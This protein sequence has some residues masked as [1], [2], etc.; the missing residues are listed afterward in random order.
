MLKD[1]Q[2]NKLLLQIIDDNKDTEYG[3]KYH[4]EYL[5]TVD[6]YKYVLPLSEV[7]DVNP[8][9]ELTTRIGENNIFVADKIIAYALTS[10]TTSI[11]HYVPVTKKHIDD[12]K[13]EFVRMLSKLGNNIVLFESI[14]NQI[15]YANM[16]KLDT[17]SGSILQEIKNNLRRYHFTS[18]ECLLFKQ[19]NID[20][21]YYRALFALN[22]A[23]VEKIIAPFSW[24][25]LE[26]IKCII[27]N[28]DKLLN[29][30]QSATITFENDTP[31]D[32]KQALTNSYKPNP[33]RCKYLSNVLTKDTFTLTDLWPQLRKVYAP[34]T[35]RF[36]IYRDNLSQYLGKAKLCNGFFVSSEAILGTCFDETDVYKLY[37]KNAYI[38]F[39]DVD[40]KDDAT[41][42]YDEVT[43]KH[44]YILY[45]TN[46]AGLYRYRVGDI[47]EVVDVKEGI[48]YF[49][50]VGRTNEKV[51]E[52]LVY[53]GIKKIM[54]A[55]NSLIQDYCFINSNKGLTILLETKDSQLLQSKQKALIKCFDKSLKV[56]D[57]KYL[58]ENSQL[59]YKALRGKLGN[60]AIDQL[61]P[62]R[63]INDQEKKKFFTSH[64]IK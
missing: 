15:V 20:T 6:G 4:F 12:Y 8:T 27:D 9:I 22:A 26:F 34:S 37:T 59:E 44:K 64:I 47:V 25:V 52:Q 3:K 55:T 31:E 11:N 30:L 49:K 57:I 51:D 2:F 40:A 53:A 24:N 5:R 61:K 43:P 42:L 23:K 48:P 14:P 63:N 62:I 38:E 60:L 46:K 19:V 21:S 45:I 58:K 29:D 17:I 32:F 35:G 18:P 36:E 10:G 54:Q 50:Y 1:N 7:E 33:I 39:K 13:N 41:V 28:K 16:A 56:I